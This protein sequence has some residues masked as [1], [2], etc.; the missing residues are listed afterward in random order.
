[1]H[2]SRRDLLDRDAPKSRIS[3]P[4]SNMTVTPTANLLIQLSLSL[5][6]GVVRALSL[7]L[8][9]DR[10]GSIP[11]FNVTPLYRYIVIPLYISLVILLLLNGG[12]V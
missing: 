6:G 5:R 11:L 4:T 9:R 7:C 3:L 8:Y 2:W 1:M 12:W 10:G